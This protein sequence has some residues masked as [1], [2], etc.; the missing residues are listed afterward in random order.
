MVVPIRRAA[1]AEPDAKVTYGM[2]RRCL[3]AGLAALVPR[4]HRNAAAR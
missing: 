4:R 3:E 2:C 1:P